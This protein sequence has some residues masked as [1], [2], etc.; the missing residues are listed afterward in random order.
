LIGIQN[1]DGSFAWLFKEAPGAL[2]NV[3]L[4]PVRHDQARVEVK[5]FWKSGNGRRRKLGEWCLDRRRMGYR[6]AR[7]GRCFTID[8]AGRLYVQVSG[9]G[10]PVQR[11]FIC[12]I[13]CG[14]Q[15]SADDCETSAGWSR[16]ASRL[17]AADDL[18]LLGIG[19]AAVIAA[20]VILIVRLL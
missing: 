6:L 9:V 1:A 20:I 7:T 11:D 19:A 14:R 18:R 5:V 16:T 3:K 4:T 8:A 15:G 13:G 10:K 12:P 17:V 2:A